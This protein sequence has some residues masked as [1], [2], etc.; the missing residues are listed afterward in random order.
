MTYTGELVQGAVQDQVNIHCLSAAAVLHN[1][2]DPLLDQ[3]KGAISY[4]ALS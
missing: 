3:F 2:R 1:L 4:V